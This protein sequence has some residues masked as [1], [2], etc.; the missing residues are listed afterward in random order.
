MSMLAAEHPE[1][2][3]SLG[4]LEGELNGVIRGYGALTESPKKRKGGK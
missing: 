1:I 2:A 3:G 4:R